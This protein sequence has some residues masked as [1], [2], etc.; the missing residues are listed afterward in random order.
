MAAAEGGGISEDH[1][2][3]R[4]GGKYKYNKKSSIGQIT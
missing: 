3:V 2:K 1:Y 4:L